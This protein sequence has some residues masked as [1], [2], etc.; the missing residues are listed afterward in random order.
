MRSPCRRKAM[1]LSR[2]GIFA[3]PT[4]TVFLVFAGLNCVLVVISYLSGWRSLA[5]RFPARNGRLPTGHRWVSVG[6]GCGDSFGS[7]CT[8]LRGM[9]L[10]WSERG[11]YVADMLRLFVFFPP[12]EILWEA[13][14][15]TDEVWGSHDIVTIAGRRLGIPMK[16]MQGIRHRLEH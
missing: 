12:L 15:L 7:G 2:F 4:T 10:G 1:P 6:F 8:L 11:L 16:V 9:F 14:Q 3:H 13:I 5:S